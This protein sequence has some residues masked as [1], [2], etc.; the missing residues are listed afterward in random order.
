[1]SRS[2]IFDLEQSMELIL[3]S[4]LDTEQ[5][6]QPDVNGTVLFDLEQESNETPNENVDNPPDENNYC[7][8]WVAKQMKLG[9]LGEKIAEAFLKDRYT[10][11][12][13]VTNDSGKGYDIQC[14]H[15]GAR[16]HVEVKT[17]TTSNTFYISK[18]EIEKA[19]EHQENYW[20]FFIRVIEKEKAIKG[21]IIQNPVV[22][23]ALPVDELIRELKSNRVVIQTCSFMIKLDSD[24][25]GE[26]KKEEHILTSYLQTV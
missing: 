6:F 11:V 22:S 26:L 20:I 3:I 1:M 14:V 25:I 10:D 21:Y 24:Y 15:A 9:L 19:K 17:T 12:K 13:N 18:N 7:P 5:R 8:D 23:L 4:K 2:Y 16:K